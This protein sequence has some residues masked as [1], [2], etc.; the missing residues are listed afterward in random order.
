MTMRHAVRWT[1]IVPSGPLAEAVPESLALSAM[2]IRLEQRHIPVDHRL[3]RTSVTE[4]I[5]NREGRPIAFSAGDA[6]RWAALEGCR[7]RGGPRRRSQGSGPDGTPV[8]SV[9]VFVSQN[10]SLSC[11]IGGNDVASMSRETAC[12]AGLRGDRAGVE[13]LV[14]TVAEIKIGSTRNGRWTPTL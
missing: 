9:G 14:S 11:S 6:R 7:S 13:R 8:S 4:N 3:L 12:K 1:P 5:N 10:W 2:H